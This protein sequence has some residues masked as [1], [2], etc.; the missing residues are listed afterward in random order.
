[1]PINPVVL[2]SSSELE[3]KPEYMH[4]NMNPGCFNEPIDIVSVAR[5]PSLEVKSAYEMMTWQSLS[6]SHEAGMGRSRVRFVQTEE[7]QGIV[8]YEEEAKG[9]K[10]ELKF[11]DL[12]Q[13]SQESSLPVSRTMVIFCG[14]EPT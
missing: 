6:V 9:L 10:K 4:P 8:E 1:M 3:L 14:G 5:L 7:V 2:E 12:L 11:C 13:W